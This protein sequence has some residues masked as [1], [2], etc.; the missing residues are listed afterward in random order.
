MSQIATAEYLDGIREGRSIR[1]IIDDDMIEQV[2]LAEI[3][4]CN[5]VKYQAYSGY[6]KDFIDG[7]CDFW[8]LQLEL[9]KQNN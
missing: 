4:F 5:K 9:N 6:H 3:A 8:K 2:A 7:F 1:K